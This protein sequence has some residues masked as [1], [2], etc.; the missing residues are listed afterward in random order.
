MS[1]S[2]RVKEELLR[3]TPEKHCCMLSE[4]SALTQTC[5]SLRLAGGGKARVIY[6][7]ENPALA[8]AFIQFVLDNQNGLV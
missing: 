6:E 5:G 3:V 4:L 7:T 1:F 2:S 8:N